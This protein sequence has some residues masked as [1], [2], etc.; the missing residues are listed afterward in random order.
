MLV[1]NACSDELFTDGALYENGEQN[2]RVTS[3][4]ASD[5]SGLQLM[6]DGTWKASRRVP[7]TGAGRTIGNMSPG[8]ITVLNG[9]INMENIINDDLNDKAILSGVVNAEALF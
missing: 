5:N 8:L 9:T 7:L 2:S 4:N 6:S 1:L 3:Q